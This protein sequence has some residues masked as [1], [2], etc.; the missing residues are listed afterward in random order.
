MQE[1]LHNACHTFFATTTAPHYLNTTHGQQQQTNM[2]V[3]TM[4]GRKH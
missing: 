3:H 2:E 4:E 1:Y